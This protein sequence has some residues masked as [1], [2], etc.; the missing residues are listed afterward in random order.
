MEGVLWLSVWD[1]ARLGT[2]TFMGEL[3]LDLSLMSHSKNTVRTYALR[4][5]V[6]LGDGGNVQT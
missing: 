3:R 1:S 6:G 4:E 2:S 5:K